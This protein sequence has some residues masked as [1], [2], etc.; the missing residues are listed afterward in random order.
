MRRLARFTFVSVCWILAVVSL[1]TVAVWVASYW[2]N[3]V[4]FTCRQVVTPIHLLQTTNVL[5]LERGYVLYNRTHSEFP[6][7]S[8]R[9]PLDN[10]NRWYDPYSRDPGRSVESRSPPR[11]DWV[12]RMGFRWTHRVRPSRSPGGSASRTV[13]VELPYWSI[14]A[15]AGL[16]PALVLAWRQRRRLRPTGGCRACGYDLRATPDGGGP[17]LPRCPECGAATDPLPTGPPARPARAARL[18]SRAATAAAV[19]VA[20]AV[21]ATLAAVTVVVVRDVRQTA[22]G[23]R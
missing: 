3:R 21:A 15:L 22:A 16:P 8:A 12:N 13:A 5:R 10:G 6:V 17:I 20:A 1:G 9:Y 18:K 7:R 11:G 2:H 14:A 19:V 23:V 4:L